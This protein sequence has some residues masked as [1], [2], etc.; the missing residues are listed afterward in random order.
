MQHET[1]Y[2]T[3]TIGTLPDKTIHYQQKQLIM[4]KKIC[5]GSITAMLLAITYAHSNA[6]GQKES[7][8]TKENIDALASWGDIKEWWNRNDYICVEVTC[9]CMPAIEY[10]ST[11]HKVVKEGTG[12][13]PHTWS[14]KGCG[15]C[16]FLPK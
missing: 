4:I 8:L 11:S 6:S 9:C 3:S 14:C 15:D 13:H 5:I 10:T 12:T 2:K 1:I 7:D 16:A